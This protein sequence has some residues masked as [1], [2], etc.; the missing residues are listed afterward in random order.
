MGPNERKNNHLAEADRL[1][2][3]ISKDIVGISGFELILSPSVMGQSQLKT[4]GKF[5][6]QCVWTFGHFSH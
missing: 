5:G 1:E 4:T 2:V 3:A 6:C